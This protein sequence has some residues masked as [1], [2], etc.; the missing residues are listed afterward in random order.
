MFKMVPNALPESVIAWAEPFLADILERS[1]GKFPLANNLVGGEERARLL[2]I[3]EAAL[4]GPVRDL[5]RARYE[6]EPA[7]CLTLSSVRHQGP[8]APDHLVGWHMDV[9]F[10]NDDKPFLV[11]WTPMEEVGKTR[12]GLEVCVPSGQSY[13]QRSLVVEWYRRKTAKIPLTFTDA[14]VDA[15]LGAENWSTRAVMAPAGTAAVFDQYV[16]HRSQLLQGATDS[17]ISIEFRL[18]DADNLPM[19]LKHQTSMYLRRTEA[20]DSELFIIRRGDRVSLKKSAFETI[21]FV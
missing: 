18:V 13:D 9:N 10:I 11:A 6:V 20:G 2:E 21:K 15:L 1:E 16:L 8:D 4:N 3:G 12:V 14:E 5:F 19:S 17:R 7:L